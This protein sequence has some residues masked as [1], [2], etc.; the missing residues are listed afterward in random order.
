MGNENKKGI[1]GGE[2]MG[3]SFFIIMVLIFIVGW[4][5]C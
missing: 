2:L 3:W 1:D 4:S 5:G